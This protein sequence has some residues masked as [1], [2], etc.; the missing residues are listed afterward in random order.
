MKAARD[1]VRG[2]SRYRGVSWNKGSQKWLARIRLGGIRQRCGLFQDEAEAG[3]AYDR[4]LLS[5]HGR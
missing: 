2:T 3:R 5:K 1:I 4:A